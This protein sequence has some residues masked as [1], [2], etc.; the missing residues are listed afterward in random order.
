M[1]NYEKIPFERGF[2]Y[3]K[4]FCL[5]MKLSTV[6]LFVCALQL[7]AATVYSQKT[8]VTFSMKDT[9]MKDVFNKIEEKILGIYR[10]SELYYLLFFYEFYYP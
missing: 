2:I 3:I 6:L 7:S 1:K 9:S 10:V 5:I 4:K 8:R